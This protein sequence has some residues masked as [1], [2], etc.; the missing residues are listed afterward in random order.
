LNKISIDPNKVILRQLESKDVGEKYVAW[1]NDPE[2]NKF[3]EIRHNV[4]INTD[5]VIKFV[6]HCN[7]KKRYHWGIFYENI[8]IGNISCS[9]ID[10]VY[11]YVN[12]SNLI[13]EKIFWNS[14]IC[15]FSLNAA[16]E[17][18][19]SQASFN[20]IE[21]GTYSIHLSG[22]TLL[23][24]LGFKKEGVFKERAIFN[25][26]YINT[27]LFGVTK[28]E[29]DKRNSEIPSVKVLRPFWE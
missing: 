9:I 8:H 24:N 20:R 4:P 26:K 11:R 18:L 23:T 7:D 29:W 6:E 1:L 3:L 10:R 2:V 15:K 13:G 28:S 25:N 5:D 14:D 27:L 17:Y 19:F 22:I 12:I 21:A 16:I